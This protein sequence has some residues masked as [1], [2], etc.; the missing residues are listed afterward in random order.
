M[1]YSLLAGALLLCSGAVGTTRAMEREAG[2]ET[3][4]PSPT[5][6]SI[7]SVGDMRYNILRCLY[8]IRDTPPKVITVAFKAICCT[9]RASYSFFKNSEETTLSFAFDLLKIAH[10]KGGKPAELLT[11]LAF[12]LNTKGFKLFEGKLA[13]GDMLAATIMDNNPN[14]G[15]FLAIL[16]HGLTPSFVSTIMS[17]HWQ[18]GLEINTL[19]IKAL[20]QHA[21]TEVIETL[22]KLGSQVND[23]PKKTPPPCLVVIREYINYRQ[24]L[25]RSQNDDIRAEL[26]AKLKSLEAIMGLLLEKGACI[27]DSLCTN[28]LSKQEKTPLSLGIKHS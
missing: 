21:P 28:T 24:K 4:S 7:F 10:S 6:L 2:T 12:N 11:P 23:F 17:Y 18:E 3:T 22:I 13:L 14:W 15:A 20:K 26:E 1:K 16:E 27:S 25:A 9:D 8:E 19:L 5:S